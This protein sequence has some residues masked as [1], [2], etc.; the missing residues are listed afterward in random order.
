MEEHGGH[1]DSL[2][3]SRGPPSIRL[4]TEYMAWCLAAVES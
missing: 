3:H 2:A 1:P 4:R